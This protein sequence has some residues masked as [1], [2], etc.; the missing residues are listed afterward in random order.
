MGGVMIWKVLWD[1]HKKV[2]NSLNRYSKG[3]GQLLGSILSE[4]EIYGA[5]EEEVVFPALAD[6]APGEIEA[7]Q[8]R[9]DN[10]K[11]LCPDIENLEA[12]DPD[13]ARLMKRVQKAWL[14]HTAREEKNLFP[15]IKT[16]LPDEQYDMARQAFT[17]RQELVA[18]RGGSSGSSQYYIGLPTGG[19]SKGANQGW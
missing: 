18:S 3:E 1:Y 14:L 7:A 6:F 12:G 11:E 15:I 19:W 17:V 10:I 5:L 16:Q 4:I 13:E 2:E 9:L 8:E